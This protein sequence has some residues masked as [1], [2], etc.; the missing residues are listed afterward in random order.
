MTLIDHWAQ[1]SM[2]LVKHLTDDNMR[3]TMMWTLEPRQKITVF[4]IFGQQH[5]LA[6]IF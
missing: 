2:G 5:G 3:M 1:I 4:S 6:P